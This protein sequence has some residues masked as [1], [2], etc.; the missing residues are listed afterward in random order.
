MTPTQPAFIQDLVAAIISHYSQQKTVAGEIAGEVK[1]VAALLQSIPLPNRHF[2]LSRHPITKY[3]EDSLEHGNS[4]TLNLIQL[5][6]PAMPFLPWRYSYSKR[7]DAPDLGERIAFAEIIGPEAPFPSRT[8]CLGLTLIGPKTFYPAH[9]H[10]AIELY[11]VIA[12]TAEWTAET[13]SRKCPPGS[14]VLHPSGLVHAMRTED[15]PLLA[16]YT[17]TGRNI[18]SPSV[19]VIGQ[20]TPPKL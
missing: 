1:N 7:E 16:I 14:F 5:L 8:V 4:S 6:R 2:P 10:P 20:P 15:Q 13:Q 9:H 17:W 11:Y 19:Y 18:I 3:I 12:G